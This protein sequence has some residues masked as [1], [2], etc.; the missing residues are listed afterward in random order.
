MS[1]PAGWYDAGTPGR[2]RWWDGTQWTEHECDAPGAALAAQPQ[3][4][5]LLQSA[6]PPTMGAAAA[7]GW[8]PVPGTPQIRWWDGH[9][10]TAYSIR[11]GLPRGDWYA[12]EPPGVG[13]AFG[14]IFIALGTAQ[15]SLSLIADSS[16]FSA[17]ASIALGLFWLTGAIS[18]SAVRAKPAPAS[19]AALPESVQPLPGQQEGPG[20]GW[21]RLSAR[22]SR[23][24]SGARWGQYVLESDRVRPTF[25]G[26]RTYRTMQVLAF[27]FIGIG[28]IALVVGILML[29]LHSFP[30]Q[31]WVGV[32]VL[33]SG[34][35]CA[36]IGAII[37]PI[38]ASR[39]HAL[40]L[41]EHPPTYVG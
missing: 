20:A 3:T 26:E 5:Q 41:P 15:L 35:V 13:Y 22:T 11:R 18:L 24:W 1:T 7:M 2:L 37:L 38:I 39:K 14:A 4:S 40:L 34:I 33:V 21:V 6:Q 32:F 19:G 23:W 36:F 30:S 25:G 27:A 16:R 10:W 12:V 8:Y 31:E 29:V 28:A 9:V 17:F